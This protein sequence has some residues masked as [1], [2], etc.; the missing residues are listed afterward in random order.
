MQRQSMLSRRMV[1]EDGRKRADLIAN[2]SNDGWFVYGDAGSTEHAQHLSHYCFRAV[3]NRVPVVRAVNTG[4]SA[5][6]DSN[7][8]VLAVVAHGGRRKMVGGTLL[9]QTL[10]DRRVSPYSRFGDVFARA[11]CVVAA[12]GVVAGLLRRRTR[13]R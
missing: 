2:L 8:R 9:A 13:K 7:G 5:H 6:V 12:A 1:Y 4:I 3:E 11:V 10:V